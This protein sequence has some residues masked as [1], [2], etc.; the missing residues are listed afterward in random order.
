[1]RTSHLALLSLLLLAAASSAVELAA[2]DMVL[3]YRRPA[4]QWLDALPIGNG[5]MG[6]MVFGG[7]PEERIALN[8]ASFW[9][10]RPHDY[11]DPNAGKYFAQIRDLVFAG[12]FQEAEKLADAHFY[13]VPAAQQAYQP[14]G[15]LL[16]SFD[17]A[18]GFED[19]R[20]ELDME[21]GVATVRYRVGDT[22]FTRAVFLSCP[23]RVMVVRITANR[24]GRVSLQAQFKSP[25]RDRVTVRP[26][27]LVMDGCWKGPLQPDNW[28]IAKVEGKGMR[29]RAVLQALPEG[30]RSEASDDTL[31]VENAD[32][33]TFLVTAGTS[34]VNYQDIGGDPAAVCARILASVADKDY[35]TLRRR[36]EED[37]RG[38]MGRV[39]LNVGAPTMNERP[40]DERIKAVHDGGDDADLEALCFQFGRYLLAS[41]S[42]AGGQPANLQGIWNESVSPNWGS[43]YTI[44]INTE[45]NYW[46]AEVGNLSECH[47]PLFDMLKDISV[48]GARTARVYY[49]CDGWVAH[50]NIDLWRGTA[51]VD[52]ARFGMWPVG[53][54]WL[55]LHLWEHY[56][57]TG[58]RQF[59]QEY[60]PIMK[61][62]ARFLLELLVE[63]PRHHWLVTPF[64][65]SPE[66]GYLDSKGQLAFLAPGPTLDITIIRELFGHC[67]EASGLLGVDEEFRGKLEAAL[68]KLP[69]Y[70]INR[71][72]FVQEWIEDWPPG[73]QGHNVSPQFPFFPGSTI[74]L[75]RDPQLAD[76]ERKWMDTRRGRGGWPMAWDICMWARL[77]RGDK[78]A[79]CIRTFVGNSVA[80]N[81]HNRGAN[82]S[83]ATFGFTAGV[84]EALLQ[85]HAGE[86]SLLP[87]LP[88]GW[89]EG[90]VQGLRARGGFEVDMRW[91]AGKLQS[92]QIRS[93]TGGSG[94]VRYGEKT[95]TFSLAPGATVSLDPDLTAAGGR[96]KED[97]LH[98]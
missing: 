43:K 21:T 82:Q 56:L 80:A 34:F 96:C 48:T 69:P 27:G 31:R 79:A 63:E 47:Q 22:V 4:V 50:H 33:V 2:R 76:A 75:R 88:A 37:F 90:A 55:T 29:F 71:R 24:P 49:G 17:G 64:S 65:M 87:A 83:D 78:V 59:L 73:D 81:L 52:A 58:D 46:P 14:L 23:D 1:M 25:Y 35:A 42:R 54:A 28:L 18:E 26:D 39:H 36:H 3:W 89:N 84:A 45:M 13:G 68:G 30:G 93:R 20:R 51:P 53:G 5:I 70:R 98:L 40:T 72:G 66:H 9:S 44:N 15:D 8:E 91:Q 62:A 97:I 10:G 61:G 16:L 19:Y 32:A 86:I 85:S 67:I 94:S 74:Q 38:L 92:A 95:A 60:Y 41:S 6:A 57:F 11:D 7:V 77:E 12:R